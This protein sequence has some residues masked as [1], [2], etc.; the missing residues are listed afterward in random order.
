MFE[1]KVLSLSEITAKT[2]LD[3]LT[4]QEI[5]KEEDFQGITS[6]EFTLAAIHEAIEEEIA[7]RLNEFHLENPMRQG[8]NKAELLQAMQNKYPKMLIEFVL[9]SGIEKKAFQR[10]GQYLQ[11]KGFLP[12]V[13]KSWQ[14]RTD[15]LIAEL[16]K[17]G[18]K[19][20]PF[21]E[22]Y[23][24]AGI[25]E[26][27]KGD[28]KRYLEDQEILVPLDAQNYWHGDHFRAAVEELKKS[29]AA[30]F[31]VGHAKEVL[32][33]SRKYMIPFLE[34]LDSLGMTR[35]TENKRIWV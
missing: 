30:E 26:N 21:D 6:K 22:Y 29:T 34:K 17:D 35:R 15:N 3:E 12:H 20:K 4:V 19:V 31:E 23:A 1:D 25:P 24:S 16:K 8:A 13:P 18:Y 9:N 14:K 33:L 28:L 32:G 2:S 5:L 11:N 10:K 27:L 7:D